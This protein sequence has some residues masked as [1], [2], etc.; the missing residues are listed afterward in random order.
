MWNTLVRLVNDCS[1]YMGKMM[2]LT[3]WSA[4]VIALLIA[5]TQTISLLKT[6]DSTPS[7]SIFNHL[8]VI[9]ATVQQTECKAKT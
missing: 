7:T 2:K 5:H 6:V 3:G 4:L 8:V 9:R 1:S